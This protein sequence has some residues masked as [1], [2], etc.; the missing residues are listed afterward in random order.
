MNELPPVAP[1]LTP[2]MIEL[3]KGLAAFPELEYDS[4][5]NDTGIQQNDIK[6]RLL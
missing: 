6:V 1:R 4:L 5:K 3:D 2:I